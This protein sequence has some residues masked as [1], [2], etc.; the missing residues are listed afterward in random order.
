MLKLLNLTLIITAVISVAVAD[1]LLK[2][3]AVQGNWLAALRS[4]WMAGAILLYLYQIAFFTYIFVTGWQ[5]SLVGSLQTVLY[6]LIVLGAG[7]FFYQESLS[8]VQIIGVCLAIS[9][10]I[11]INLD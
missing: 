2:K 8:G 7:V 5:L 10:A 11:L 3:A 1:V 9:G 6:A 4:P